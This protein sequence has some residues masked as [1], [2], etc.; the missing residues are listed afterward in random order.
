[1]ERSAQDQ[2]L[3]D[4]FGIDRAAF[5]GTGSASTAAARGGA[6]ADGLGA[7]GRAPVK[8]MA[9]GSDHI[10]PDCKPR[11]GMVD[12][13][14]NHVLCA[15]HGHVYDEDTGQI[16]ADSIAD[17]D[18]QPEHKVPRPQA[19]DC[20]PVRGKMP[21]APA[22]IMLCGA[23]GHV[24]NMD[25]K[26][27]V[28]NTLAMFGRKQVP[29]GHASPPPPG[30]APDPGPQ[31]PSPQ[32]PPPGPGPIPPNPSPQPDPSPI[33]HR[34]SANELAKLSAALD[35]AEGQIRGAMA[36]DA[37]MRRTINISEKALAER[38]AAAMPSIDPAAIKTLRLALAAANEAADGY[39]ETL[40]QIEGGEARLKNIKSLLDLKLKDSG[41]Q[42]ND[43][44]LDKLTNIYDTMIN[45]EKALLDIASSPD[46]LAIGFAQGVLELV[47]GDQ[48]KKAFKDHVQK[49]VDDLIT[50]DKEID[51][52]LQ[53]IVS[54]LNDFGADEAATEADQITKLTA[55]KAK[56]L[57]HW[58]TAIKNYLS[59]LESLPATGGGRPP[60][61]FQDVV[62]DNK[63][64]IENKNRLADVQKRVK[65]QPALRDTD[66]LGALDP[67]GTFSPQLTQSLAATHIDGKSVL[68]YVHDAKHLT[69][70]DLPSGMGQ[71]ELEGLTDRIERLKLFDAAV[72]D[73]AT[74][75]EK[76]G[77]TI[78]SGFALS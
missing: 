55:L 13:P 11:R 5:A 38:L 65:Q 12:G 21:K 41:G 15:T 16:L 78:D 57:E 4:A 30:P 24:L 32:P 27:I 26:E 72:F 50:K 18:A 17:Y 36:A 8:S 70:F 33:T 54:S 44:Q 67:I 75:A 19:P 7:D 56:R 66:L 22:N 14:K 42:A 63:R 46:K 71:S 69:L 37:E 52:H 20:K 73:A 29:G 59:D 2:W 1:M 31:P 77:S 51:G 45:A 53:T 58:S 43:D 74:L 23:H 40:I 3:L 6:I 47:G 76:W 10:T 34:V 62:D 9:A 48:V 25:T 35:A 39:T 28:A 49:Q 61:A 68:V 64:I 60:K